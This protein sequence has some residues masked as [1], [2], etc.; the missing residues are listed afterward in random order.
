M[1]IH[2]DKLAYGKLEKLNEDLSDEDILKMLSEL[3][4]DGE[5]DGQIKPENAADEKINKS[6]NKPLKGKNINIY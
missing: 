6:K 3:G 2:H 1:T 5:N 4:N